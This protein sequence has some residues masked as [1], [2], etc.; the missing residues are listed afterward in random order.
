MLVEFT[1]M[2]VRLERHLAEQ[3]WTAFLQRHERRV[4]K[5][6]PKPDKYPASAR[7]LTENLAP[8]LTV[9]RSSESTAD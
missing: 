4:S 9:R 8:D 3:S 7:L 1:K 2:C 6:R 5:G